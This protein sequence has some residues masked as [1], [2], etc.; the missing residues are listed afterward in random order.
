[1]KRCVGKHHAQ[2]TR[3]GRN[4]RGDRG[5]GAAPG[6]HDRALRSLE[7][8]TI[9]GAHHDQRLGSG[10]IGGHQRERLV[11]AMLAGAQLGDGRVGAR[12]AGE[13][14]P[15]QSLD[16]ED[17]ALGDE[18]RRVGHRVL[19]IRGNRRSVG[20]D[21][22]SSG[23]AHR[24]RVRLRMEPP[25]ARILVLSPAG[26]AHLE[27]GHGGERPVVRHA[28]HDREPRTAVRA[29]RERIAIAAIRR[30]QQL[31]QALGAG[32]RVG[33]DQRQRLATGRRRGDPELRATRDGGVV[34]DHALDVR[35]R[36]RLAH[37]APG[38]GLDRVDGALD[39]QQHAPLVVQHPPAEAQLGCEPKDKR[40]E[41]DSL[42]RSR[43]PHPRPD[44]DRALRH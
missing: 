26:V 3:V 17:R 20:R 37:H 22:P 25:V 27:A 23:A 44:A 41:P 36:G 30:V 24:A 14:V 16:A 12:Q 19:R 13:V 5:A 31:S 32:R 8:P 10:E 7:Q 28:P 4:R 15:A 21:H 40:P 33:R 35:Q 42:H 1:M 39:L 29:V 34:A 2:V 38:E 43:D 9:P 11:L 6:D 18:L